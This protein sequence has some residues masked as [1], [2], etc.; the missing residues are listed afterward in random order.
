MDS[1][2]AVREAVNGRIDH[3]A[4]YE[5]IID[6]A[7]AM[8]PGRQKTEKTLVAR[9]AD[10]QNLIQ[11]AMKQKAWSK[12]PEQAAELLGLNPYE[13]RA[14]AAA[15]VA[16]AYVRCTQVLWNEYDPQYKVWIP[17][18]SIGVLAIIALGIFGQM[19][20]RWQDMNA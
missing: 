20:K 14:Q 1:D 16:G 17:F 11:A 18:A 5:G 15:E 6:G 13:A 10:R 7:K 9:L 4:W 8:L 3:K 19:A 2:P 12:R